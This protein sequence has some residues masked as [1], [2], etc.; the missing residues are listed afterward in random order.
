[1]RVPFQWVGRVQRQGSQAL[2]ANWAGSQGCPPGTQM[3]YHPKNWMF[4]NVWVTDDLLCKS[5]ETAKKKVNKLETDLCV[6]YAGH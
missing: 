1:M 5:R 3:L 4:G 6:T 2:D